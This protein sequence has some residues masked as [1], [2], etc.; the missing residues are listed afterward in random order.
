MAT[1][2]NLITA[3]NGFLTS[4]VTI[5]KHRNSMLEAVNELFP[6]TNVY[7]VTTGNIQYKLRFTKSGNL[8]VVNGY[9]SNNSANPITGK[10][11][12]ITN[13]IYYPKVEQDSFLGVVNNNTILKLIIGDSLFVFPNSLYVQGNLTN[14]HTA[15]INTTYIV[16]D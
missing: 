4:T 12:D 8:C 6:T 14:G 1:K 15:V 7:E 9:I 13:P 10:L 2:S 5:T 11:F 16:N 3:I